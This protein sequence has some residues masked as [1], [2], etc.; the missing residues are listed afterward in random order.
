MDRRLFWTIISN[1]WSEIDPCGRW[2]QVALLFLV[3]V[4]RRFSVKVNIHLFHCGPVGSQ[5]F[6]FL[7]L[8]MF[9]F[10]HLF[11]Y[12]KKTKGPSFGLKLWQHKNKPSCESLSPFFFFF[13]ENPN[14]NNAHPSYHDAAPFGKSLADNRLNSMHCL[15]CYFSHFLSTYF[16]IFTQ[17]FCCTNPKHIQLIYV[18][19]SI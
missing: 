10:H 4:N 16:L 12:S 8:V 13:L 11:P 5:R 18:C 7:Y 19:N 14:S 6:F 3:W 2:L 1:Y 9:S 17:N 15:S